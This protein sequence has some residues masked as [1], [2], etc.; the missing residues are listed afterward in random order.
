MS[1]V[2]LSIALCEWLFLSMISPLE[3]LLEGI[4][5]HS[6]F[7]GKICKNALECSRTFGSAG[8]TGQRTHRARMESAFCW[9]RWIFANS[10]IIPRKPRSVSARSALEALADR[11]TGAR[12]NSGNN[13]VVGRSC[14]SLRPLKLT[15]DICPASESP[16]D[17]SG[18]IIVQFL[19]P[20]QCSFY[21]HLSPQAPVHELRSVPPARYSRV[22]PPGCA[23]DWQASVERPARRFS[24]AERECSRGRP[25]LWGSARR[26]AMRRGVFPCRAGCNC[27]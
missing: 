26:W 16:L 22:R 11:A 15:I 17:S 23:C 8:V 4:I 10:D 24:S 21:P 6:D 18:Y 20:L 12:E 7:Y 25:S 27:S 14:S 2:P 19:G 5:H 3:V 9:F 1:R 13:R